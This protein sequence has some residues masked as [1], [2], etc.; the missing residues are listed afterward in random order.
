MSDYQ[1][2]PEQ[3]ERD[4]DQNE[5]CGRD[6]RLHMFA[7]NLIRETESLKA[8]V[9]ELEAKRDEGSAFHAK[10]QKRL[11]DLGVPFHDG[12]TSGAKGIR[13]ENRLEWLARRVQELE[14]A[15]RRIADDAGRKQGLYVTWEARRAA[16]D[17][18]DLAELA[19]QAI[20]PTNEEKE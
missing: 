3:L 14:E 5:R 15:L 8:R 9:Q 11:D 13:L 1:P 7:A 17:F 12:V 18:G 16:R 20:S 2:T 19:R 6:G 4:G 10:L